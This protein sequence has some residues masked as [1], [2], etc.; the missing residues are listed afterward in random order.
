MWYGCRTYLSSRSYEYGVLWLDSAC[1]SN[2]VCFSVGLDRRCCPDR[3]RY[4]LHTRP[5]RFFHEFRLSATVY[6]ADIQCVLSRDP[7]TRRRGFCAC[8]DLHGVDTRGSCPSGLCACFSPEH[9]LGVSHHTDSLV[10]AGGPQ[11]WLSSQ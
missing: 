3:C 9:R 7:L 2:Q 4:R 11:L 10:N 5:N 6:L 8:M 1:F